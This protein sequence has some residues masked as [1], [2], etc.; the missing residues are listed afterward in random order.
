MSGTS[1]EKRKQ[2]QRMIH[3]CR[4]GKIDL[5]LVKNV[6]RFMRNQ[7]DCLS[8]TRELANLSPPVGV[9]FETDNIDTRRPGYELHLG[10]YSAFAQAESENKSQ[11]IKWSNERRWNKGV[12][13]CNTEQFFGYAKNENGEMKIISGEARLIRRIY[14]RY[15]SGQN[16]RQIAQWLTKTGT[17]TF[18]GNVNWSQ[19]SVRNILKNEVYCGDLIRPKSFTK[20]FLNR[21]VIRNTGQRTRFH[22]KEHHPAI[23]G[24]ELWEKVQEQLKYPRRAGD[25]LRTALRT[26]RMPG[27]LG[28]FYLLDPSWD[29]YDLSRVRNM[30]FPPS[31]PITDKEIKNEMRTSECK[32]L[33]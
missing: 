9:V 27:E 20:S 30:L 25:K 29:G 12:M 33:I 15:N 18:Y 10:F 19:S 11:S 2:F 17:P 22:Q 26:H 5:I 8:Y 4:D 28:A 7:V 14:N 32:N 24:R 3:D 16:V 21:K 1:A 31:P 13:H 23:I 6:S